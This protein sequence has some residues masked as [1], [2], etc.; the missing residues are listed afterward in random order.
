MFRHD[1]VKKIIYFGKRLGLFIIFLFVTS[2][3]CQAQKFSHIIFNFWIFS[4]A[5]KNAAISNVGYQN[6]SNLQV[7]LIPL[8][9]LRLFM[10]PTINGTSVQI[11]PEL[12]PVVGT[13]WDTTKTNV[14]WKVD[15]SVPIVMCESSRR[16]IYGLTSGPSILTE[17]FLATTLAP[18]ERSS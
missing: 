11:A 15:L 14:E 16:A 12:T 5:T 8:P 17:K 6:V 18:R 9:A 3:C 2:T 10:R 13:W 7:M 4:V 1:N